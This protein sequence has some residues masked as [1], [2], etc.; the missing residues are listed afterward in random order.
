LIALV[1]VN[2]VGAGYNCVFLILFI[3]VG[4]GVFILGDMSLK[5]NT[6][7]FEGIFN[8]L[9]LFQKTKLL[10]CYIS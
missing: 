5:S 3:G 8:K 2:G 6:N 1:G 10:N 4:T 9:T 7:F